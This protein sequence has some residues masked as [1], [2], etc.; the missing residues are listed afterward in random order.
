VENEQLYTKNE[1]KNAKE[2]YEFLWNSGYPSQEEAVHLLQ[3]G[4]IFGLPHLTREDMQ[5]AYDIYGV[6]P[7]YVRGKMTARTTGCMPADP[8]AVMQEKLQVL[9]T[10]VMQVDGHKFLVSVVEPLQL[11]IQAH[12]QNETATQLGLGIQ[13]HLGVLRTRGFQPTTIYTDPQAGFRT[14]VGQFPNV[15]LDIGGAKVFVSKV[16]HKIR[17]I[18]ELYRSVKAGLPWTLPP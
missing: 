3:D 15:N 18:K 9:Y 16:D 12:L 8:T 6:P 1:I 5:R 14:L 17:Q 10:D 11:T 4:N 13:G 7:E 2:A